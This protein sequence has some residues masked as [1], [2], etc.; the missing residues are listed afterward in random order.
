LFERRSLVP[1]IDF[2]YQGLAQ[3]LDEDAYGVRL[4]ARRL[5][6]VVA[7]TSCSK[8]F[9]L[10]RE[11]VGA[12]S[13]VSES[14]EGAK[15]AL[16]NVA[17][18]ARGIYSMPP[19]HGAA[20]VAQILHD[21]KLRALWIDELAQMRGRLNGLRELLVTALKE[22]DTPFDFSFIAK[23][24]GLFSFLGITKEQVIRLREEFHIYMIE[25]SRINVAGINHANVDYVADS[26]AAVLEE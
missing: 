9:G 24:R 4:M 26:I 18:V 19:D 21:E 2:A 14:A 22:R 10:Y 3:G 15:L 12:A 6:E 11:R 1:F 13:F 5:P 23:E 16:M 7:V 17:N 8:N 20:I 25:S